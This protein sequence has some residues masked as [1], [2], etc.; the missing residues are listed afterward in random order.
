M[1]CYHLW[2]WDRL[3]AGKVNSAICIPRILY[4]QHRLRNPLASS[5]KALVEHHLVE[6]RTDHWHRCNDNLQVYGIWTNLPQNIHLKHPNRSQIPLSHYLPE[7]WI[8]KSPQ[9]GLPFRVLH[10]LRTRSYH[11]LE[12]AWEMSDLLLRYLTAGEWWEC[13]CVVCI[14]CNLLSLF[15]YH[16]LH[17]IWGFPTNVLG[18]STSGKTQIPNWA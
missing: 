8:S 4:S 16:G 5:G 17:R 7:S 2:W 11:R 1:I 15:W 14:T 12:L 6:N 18:I 3:I 13:L 10:L 9:I